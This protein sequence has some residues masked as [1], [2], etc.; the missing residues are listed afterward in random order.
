M[1]KAE[2]IEAVARNSKQHKKVVAMTLDLTFDQIA[3][4]IRKDKRFWM[5]G[6]GTFSVRRHRARK[7]FNPQTNAAMTIPA[8]RTIGFRPAPRLKDSL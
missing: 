1:T 6:F 4:A 3:R 2:L 8:A 5:P 7:G